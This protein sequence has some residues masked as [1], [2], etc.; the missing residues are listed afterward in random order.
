MAPLAGAGGSTLVQYGAE[1]QGL[2]FVGVPQ[3]A[4]GSRSPPPARPL[5]GARFSPREETPL[6][7]RGRKEL[8]S[9][10]RLC[11]WYHGPRCSLGASPRRGQGGWPAATQEGRR[12]PRTYEATAINFCRC[13]R[14]L[15]E[16]RRSPPC[17][18]EL[19][20]R[21]HHPTQTSDRAGV[22]DLID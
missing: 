6:A 16:G 2:S 5:P 4:P 3:K 12:S 8:D 18:W 20:P 19:C 21:Q 17:G 9:W 15:G 7:S 10:A 22:R 14:L 13:L 1:G 11:V